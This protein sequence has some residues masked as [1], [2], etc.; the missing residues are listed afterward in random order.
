[1]ADVRPGLPDPHGFR[2]IEEFSALLR[3]RRGK[4][5]NLPEQDLLQMHAS[6]LHLHFRYRLQYALERQL[7]AL[8]SP[9]QLLHMVRSRFAICLRK[10]IDPRTDL[11]IQLITEP[12]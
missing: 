1:M 6:L 12:K 8:R 5:E 9:L 3:D 10:T 2:D 11:T 4:P 7:D